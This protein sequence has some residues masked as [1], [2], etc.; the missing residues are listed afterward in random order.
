MN[1]SLFIVFEGVDKSGKS[2]QI[3]LLR[4]ALTAKGIKVLHT[5]EPTYYNVG[6]VIR[7]HLTKQI[8]VK[9][10]KALTA[11]YVADRLEHIH[12]VIDPFLQQQNGIVLCDRYEPSTEVYQSLQGVDLEWIRKLH[13][14]IID[15][16]IIFYLD[17]TP[18]TLKQ[19]LSMENDAE[20]FERIDFLLEA[21]KK[22]DE[23]LFENDTHYNWSMLY[24]IEEGSIETTHK[25]ILS[26][27]ESFL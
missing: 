5:Y 12:N 4:N 19:R 16:D 15:P 6:A 23:I 10:P 17:I 8:E 1:K 7:K 18:E 27:M 2:T 20:F 25:E 14:Y 26:I 24:R 13:E 11:M 3:K 9:D 22:Y 21:R